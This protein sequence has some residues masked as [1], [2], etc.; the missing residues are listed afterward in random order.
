MKEY[1]YCSP[2][3]HPHPWIHTMNYSIDSIARFSIARG[4]SHFAFFPSPQRNSSF[5]T[6][7]Q[8]VQKQPYIP[9]CLGRNL[10][11][12]RMG[13][14]NMCCSPPSLFFSIQNGE[15]RAQNM[16]LRGL[17]YLDTQGRGVL[18]GFFWLILSSLQH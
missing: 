1:A 2:L 7:L 9:S 16:G 4:R 11:M 3:A 6:Y 12:E 17:I 18:S 14:L 13:L 10:S 15:G 5:D 8:L